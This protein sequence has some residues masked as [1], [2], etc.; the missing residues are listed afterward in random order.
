VRQGLLSP[1][2][3]R[4]HRWRNVIT[5]ALGAG[6]SFKLELHALEVRAG[7]R[8]LLCSDGLSSVVASS[9]LSQAL[10]QLEPQAAADALIAEADARGSPDNVTAVVVAVEAV[11]ATPKRYETPLGEGDPISLQ[12]A[13]GRSTL[14]A[15]EEHFPTRSLLR[16]YRRARW[17]P[18]LPWILASAGMI[19]LIGA[20]LYRRLA[21]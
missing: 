17:F 20:F 5:N 12:V 3:A 19:G 11:A 4:R 6:E 1:E 7:D 8:Y 15:L 13:A 2:E 21:G 10:A 16:R 9:T 18:Y 14:R